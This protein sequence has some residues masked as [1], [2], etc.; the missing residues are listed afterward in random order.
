MRLIMLLSRIGAKPVRLLHN[1][2]LFLLC[3]I[4]AI[5]CINTSIPYMFYKFLG[6]LPSIHNFKHCKPQ[7]ENEPAII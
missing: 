7:T 3:I 5:V 4:N 6:K 1:I 2:Y